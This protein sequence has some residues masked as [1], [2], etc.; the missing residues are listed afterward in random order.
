MEGKDQTALLS[1]DS[2]SLLE[3]V[4]SQGVTPVE[5]RLITEGTIEL[6]IEQRRSISQ[7]RLKKMKGP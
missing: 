3:E 1:L 5:S 4:T 7:C 6:D 2:L